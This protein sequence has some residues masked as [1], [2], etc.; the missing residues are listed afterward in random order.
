VR[1]GIVGEGSCATLSRSIA[2]LLADGKGRGA[3]GAI[4]AYGLLRGTAFLALWRWRFA[5][6]QG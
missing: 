3:G 2:R 1:Q 6:F 5:M 4:A